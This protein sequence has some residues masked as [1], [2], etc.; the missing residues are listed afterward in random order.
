MLKSVDQD[1]MQKLIA[2]IPAE[3]AN[4]LSFKLVEESFLQIKKEKKGTSNVG[5]VKFVNLFFVN[6]PQVMKK[7]FLYLCLMSLESYRI[8]QVVRVVLQTSYKCIS[9]AMERQQHD[10]TANK[11][12]LDRH[13]SIENSLERLRGEDAPDDVL[14]EV[15]IFHYLLV[16]ILDIF[17]TYETP[18]C[19][20]IDLRNDDRSR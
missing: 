2:V 11:R 7:C 17:R 20:S 15:T 5:I 6:L 10:L 8:A 19:F 4:R 18:F 14:A 16:N 13:A 9:N 12:L 3:V 1:Q